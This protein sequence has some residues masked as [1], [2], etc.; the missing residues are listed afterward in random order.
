MS[1]PSL[2]KIFII[3]LNWNGKQDTL[4]CLESLNQLRY[5]NYHT[6]L[7]DNGSTDGSV[8]VI[9]ERFPQVHCLPLA[10]NMGFSGGNNAG[11]EYALKLGADY[12][13]LLNNDTVVAPDLLEA[14]LEGFAAYPDAGIL[15]ARIYLFDRQAQGNASLTQTLDHLGGIWLKKQGLTQLVG[16]REKEPF[17]DAYIPLDYACGACI[18]IKRAVIDAIG[19]LEPLYFLYW[20]DADFCMRAKA[21][22][23]QVLSSPKAKI[24]HKVSA[25]VVGGKTHASYFS[26]RGRLLWIH[27]HYKPSEKAALYLRIILPEILALFFRVLRR[28]LAIS[29]L[30]LICPDTDYSKRKHHLRRSRAELTGV[31]HYFLKRFGK[32]PSWIYTNASQQDIL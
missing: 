11:I 10:Q 15:G 21:A 13:L 4:A 6:I 28:T 23:Y 26:W 5:R 2:P 19:T 25:S 27:R 16:N 3:I 22:G 20:E 31:C 8:E 1:N 7:V 24:W 14:F 32:G 12:V 30:S 29:A 9:T 18:M 17:S